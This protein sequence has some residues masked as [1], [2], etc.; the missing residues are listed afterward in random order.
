[1]MKQAKNI[2][3]TE[4]TQELDTMKQLQMSMPMAFQDVRLTEE[5]NK[6]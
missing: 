5:A 2:G 1:M 3:N 6:Y 4:Q